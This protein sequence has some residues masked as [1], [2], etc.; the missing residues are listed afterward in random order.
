[1]VEDLG[2]AGFGLG[3]QGLIENVKNILADLLELG[4]NLLAVIAD[5][6]NMLL[7]SLRLLLLF[8]RGDDA[9]RGTSGTHDVLVRNR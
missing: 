3:N 8:D 6:G 9:P 4:L 7:G 1:M 2:L 5:G